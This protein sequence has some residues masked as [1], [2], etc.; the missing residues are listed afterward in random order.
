MQHHM[1]SHQRKAKEHDVAL[2]WQE[3]RLQ[4]YFTVKGRINYFVVTDDN[5]NSRVPEQASDSV[6]LT[7]PEKKLFDKLNKNYTDVKQNL[8]K[9]ASIVHDFKAKSKKVPWLKQT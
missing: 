5:K 1:F 4:T 9:Q 2:L 8:K 7:Q 3:C 6:L